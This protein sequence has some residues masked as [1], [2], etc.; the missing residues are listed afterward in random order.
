MS[1]LKK[2]LVIMAACGMS[3]AVGGG[4]YQMILKG[5]LLAYLVSVCLFVGCMVVADQVT[6]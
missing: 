2:E 3:F 5:D 6:K 1:K 4:T